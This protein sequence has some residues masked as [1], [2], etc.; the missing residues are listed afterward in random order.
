MGSSV[1][2]IV[3][4]LAGYMALL[5]AFLT[6]EVSFIIPLALF[7]I[8][9]FF[10]PR[11]RWAWGIVVGSMVLLGALVVYR[12]NILGSVGSVGKQHDNVLMAPFLNLQDVRILVLY[13]K[14][15]A[16]SIIVVTFLFVVTFIKYRHALHIKDAPVKLSI[17]TLLIAIASYTPFSVSYG[18]APRFLY[19]FIFFC[20]ISFITFYTYIATILKNRLPLYISIIGMMLLVFC[21][22]RTHEVVLRYQQVGGA[23]TMIINQITT[24]FPLWPTDKDMVLYNFPDSNNNVLA[25]LTYFDKAVLREYR[26][27]VT[28][29]VY[30]ADQLSIEKLETVLAKN[31]IKYDFIGFDKGV[32]R[33]P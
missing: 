23:Y 28:G 8:M 11:T 12:I 18:A 27:Q 25:F 26:G 1:Y 10:G 9:L 20:I 16:F 21:G 14:E 2:R 13:T 33:I 3:Y 15:I 22:Y 19:T 29:K 17:L 30:R 6:Y 5:A 7:G 32:K 24:D 31:P 4:A